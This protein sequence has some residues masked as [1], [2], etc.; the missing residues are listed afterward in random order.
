MAT[1]N[2]N[3]PIIIPNGHKLALKASC[4]IPIKL[5]GQNPYIKN[6]IEYP[7]MTGENTRKTSL[8]FPFLQDSIN[9]NIATPIPI[10]GLIRIKNNPIC[11]GMIRPSIERKSISAFLALIKV[12]PF[13][14]KMKIAQ[15]FTF[16]RKRTKE[17]AVYVKTNKMAAPK[18]GDK[19]AIGESNKYAQGGKQLT[20]RIY[21]DWPEINFNDASRMTPFQS[22][23]QPQVIGGLAFSCTGRNEYA[24]KTKAIK[25]IDRKSVV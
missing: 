19:R 8:N 13:S 9:Q 17:Y 16:I 6:E 7:I 20:L 22:T 18:A 12:N 24:A 2:K 10:C 21:G 11:G 15:G 5:I 23:P 14:I 25:E 4:V 1:N 3:I